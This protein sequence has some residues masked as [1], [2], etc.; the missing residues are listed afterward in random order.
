MANHYFVT[1]ETKVTARQISA[2]LAR[3]NVERFFGDMT[4]ASDC[5]AYWDLG[6]PT[7]RVVKPKNPKRLPIIQWLL[8]RIFYPARYDAIST[9]CWL[10]RSGMKVE[11]RPSCQ[12]HD[13]T[14]IIVNEIALAFDGTIYG[15]CNESETWKGKP[16]AY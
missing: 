8:K 5:E 2:L 6:N 1:F 11:I 12:G 10:K 4:V 9:Q 16:G 3:L 14:H 15:E 13:F 7:G